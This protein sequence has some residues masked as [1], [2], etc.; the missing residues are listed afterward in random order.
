MSHFGILITGD[1]KGDL[2]YFSG[3]IDVFR[4]VKITQRDIDNFIL[5]KVFKWKRNRDDFICG[6]VYKI[7]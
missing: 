2:Q 7:V 1:R 4:D 3:K 6:V 5:S